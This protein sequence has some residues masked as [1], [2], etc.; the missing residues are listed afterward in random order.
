MKN[1]LR[2]IVLI[3]LLSFI[4]LFNFKIS[5]FILNLDTS[6]LSEN[7]GYMSMLSIISNS[8]NAIYIVL[9]L[10]TLSYFFVFKDSKIQK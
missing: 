6:Y 10:L 4:N 1:K 7:E 5:R 3:I 2:G 9:C 8:I